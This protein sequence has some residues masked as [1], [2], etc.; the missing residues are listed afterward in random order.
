ML[1]DGVVFGLAI[2]AA[3]AFAWQR[4]GGPQAGQTAAFVVT[5]LSPQLSAFVLREGRLWKKFTAPNALLKGFSLAMIAMI[6]LLVFVPFCQR[7][8][9]TVA[10][11]DPLVWLV[12][13]GLS[14]VSPAVRL[15]LGRS[16]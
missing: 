15:F 13:V 14:V 10:L 9:G 8:F 1:F 5:L 6:P 16:S 2:T 12:V 3:Y 11:T 4:A 7:V